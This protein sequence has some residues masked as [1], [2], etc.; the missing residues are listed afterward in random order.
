MALTS[1]TLL[2]RKPP[3]FSLPSTVMHMAQ[4]LFVR[5]LLSHSLSN[6]CLSLGSM[7]TEPFGFHFVG[8][9]AN[10]ESQDIKKAIKYMSKKKKKASSQNIS[11]RLEL[12]MLILDMH[13][14][15]CNGHLRQ[16][17]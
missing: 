16:I 8:V 15:L 5:G 13:C 4:Q 3:A 17:L 11:H 2:I 1:R 9:S 6:L 14:M 10:P 7:H 12:L